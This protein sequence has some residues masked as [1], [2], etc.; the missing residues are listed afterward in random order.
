MGLKYHILPGG[1]RKHYYLSEVLAF[2]KEHME[3]VG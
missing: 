2:L 1:N 3:V